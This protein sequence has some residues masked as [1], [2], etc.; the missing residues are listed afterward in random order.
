MVAFIV[1]HLLIAGGAAFAGQAPGTGTVGSVHDM[2]TFAFVFNDS[3]GRVCAFCHVPH[4][5]NSE[6]G[7]LWAKPLDQQASGLRPYTWTAPENLRISQN[8]D[9]LVGPSRLCMTCHDGAIAIDPHGTKMPAEKTISTDLN[10]THPIGFSYDEAVTARGTDQLAEK[11]EQY[12][13]AVTPS[14]TPGVYNRVTR[15]AKIRIVDLLYQG[16]ILTCVSCHDVHNKNNV[17]PDPGHDYNFL[18]WA[19]EE[20]SLICLSCHKK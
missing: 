3:M 19:K 2:N 12:A 16:E 9:P 7:T 11:T 4:H 20:N 10:I 18:L 8:L 15:E 13:T 14:E 17:S 5:A 6:A 1:F